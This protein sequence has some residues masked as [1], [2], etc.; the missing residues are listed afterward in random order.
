MNAPGTP[1]YERVLWR[2]FRA[3]LS[4]LYSL[5]VTW[6]TLGSTCVINLLLAFAFSNAALQGIV[7]IAGTL[8][9]GLASVS[10]AQAGFIVFGI[11]LA[12]SE[13]SGGQICTTWAV[14][15]RRG[16]QLFAFL[17]A[18]SFVLI[19]AA[20]AVPVLGLVL[21]HFIYGGADIMGILG[22]VGMSLLGVTVYLTLT[23]LISAAIGIMLRRM[24]PAVAVVLGYYFIVG[25]LIRDYAPFAKYLPDT[26][27]VVLWFPPTDHA[28]TPMQG[29][30]VLLAWTMLAVGIAAMLYRYRDR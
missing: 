29:G 10:Y 20:F 5:P 23:A 12:C 11:L 3:E 28:L 1:R 15:P 24:L 8:E 25:P 6:I 16:I 2:A 22:H 13:Y 18:L 19:P 14:M 27:G 4:K 30:I 7:S 26:A 9:I 17:L 21:T